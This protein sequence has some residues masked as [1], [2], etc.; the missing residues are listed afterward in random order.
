MQRYFKVK[1][2]FNNLQ[3]VTEARECAAAVL[4]SWRKKVDT[5]ISVVMEGVQ[6]QSLPVRGCVKLNLV[7]PGYEL[8]FGCELMELSVVVSLS[9]RWQKNALS[10]FG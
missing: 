1:G 8:F 4:C 7:C 3:L 6:A 10:R 9:V 5:H 2:K